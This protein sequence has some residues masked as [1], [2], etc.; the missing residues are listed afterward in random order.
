MTKSTS[1]ISRCVVA[2]A[3]VASLVTSASPALADQ[4][5]ISFWVPGLFG[6]FAASPLAPGLSAATIYYHTSVS[7]SGGLAAAKQ[8][9]IGNWRPV[10]PM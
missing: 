4:G 10:A 9:E 3:I 7:A 1:A 8:I 6:S 5:G 2:F